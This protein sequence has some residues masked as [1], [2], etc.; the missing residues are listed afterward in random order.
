MNKLEIQEKMVKMGTLTEYY[1]IYNRQYYL[2]H[3]EYYK[4]YR[5]KYRETHKEQAKKYR[6]THK[7][8][9]KKYEKKYYLTHLK[10]SKQYH[11]IYNK[12]YREGHEEQEKQRSKQYRKENP[13]KVKKSIRQWRLANPKKVSEIRKRG[14]SKHRQLDFNPWN[15]PFKRCEGHHLTKDDVIYLPKEL[16]RSIYHNIWTGQNMDIINTL[17]IQFLEK[18][19]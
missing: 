16:H 6:E 8:Q 10:Q 12:Q 11:K 5:K 2:T 15:K 18:T 1:K 7:K 19:L 14:E 4:I 13:E 17:A 3:K 9:A